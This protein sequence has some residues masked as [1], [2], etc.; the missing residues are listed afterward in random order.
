MCIRGGRQS[1]VT[2]VLFRIS[3]LLE[4]AQHEVREDPL[5]GF[6]GNLFSELLIHARSDVDFFRQF[7][8][9]HAFTGTVTRPSIRL[10]LHALNR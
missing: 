10:K 8:F 1:K 3:R 2:V 9:A 4:R 7:D 5:F 6:A